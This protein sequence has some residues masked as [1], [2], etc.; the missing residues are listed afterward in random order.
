MSN[1]ANQISGQLS[2]AETQLRFAETKCA[3]DTSP[4]LRVSQSP[5]PLSPRLPFLPLAPA[6]CLLL[7]L[8]LPMIASAGT[9][10]RQTSGTLGWLHSVYF[11]NQK[12]GWAVGSKGSLLKTDDGGATWKIQ[13]R[14]TEDSIQDVYFSTPQNGW[15]VCEANIYELRT[16]KAPHL[17]AAYR[18][19]RRGLGKG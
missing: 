7:L 4:R 19:R 9:W 8:C 16:R 10:G 13:N 1:Q 14:P 2:C 11:L 12:T 17:L 6:V 3:G 15:L 18:R 5:R